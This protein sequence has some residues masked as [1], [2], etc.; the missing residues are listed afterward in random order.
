MSDGEVLVSEGAES[1]SGGDIL[2]SLPAW[3]PT[4]EGTGNFKLLDVVG[5]AIDRTEGD[6]RDL[7]HATS[8]QEAESIEQI[9]ALSRILQLPQKD[10]E[11]LEKYRT[12][13]MAEF[14]TLT[15]EGTI[16]DMIGNA[17][18]I[19]NTDRSNISYQELNENGVVKLGLPG[20]ALNELS[21]T[22]SEFVNIISKHTAAGYRVEA[23][24]RGTFTFLTPTEYTNG[25]S[26]STL[27]YDKLDSN[28]DP[29][30]SGGTYAGLL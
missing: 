1:E 22:G 3:M 15:S 29:T 24:I 25:D 9:E 10:G 12:R 16:S 6:V 23:S 19:M 2:D 28:G 20:A 8:I 18:T 4:D 13:S 7:D 30:G 21:I 11:G 26:D 27:G 5:R 14:Q 17:A